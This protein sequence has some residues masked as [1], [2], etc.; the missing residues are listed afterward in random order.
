MRLPTWGPHRLTTSVLLRKSL[1]GYC[2]TEAK[3]LSSCPN[4]NTSEELSGNC[5]STLSEKENGTQIS[6]INADK[7]AKIGVYLR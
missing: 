5:T 2:G 7:R 1:T 6:P 4:I 3:H